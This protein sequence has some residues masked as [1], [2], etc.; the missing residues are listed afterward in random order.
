MAKSVLDK[1]VESR[2]MPVLFIG[3]GIS[4]RYLYNF[5]DW[6]NLLK[7]SFK[8]VN[9]DPFYYGQ[10]IE[11][12][13]R[14]NL[15]DFERNIRLAS[16]IENDYN[17]AFYSRKVKIKI[18]NSKNP[19]WVEQGISPYKM[20]LVN[21]F[22]KL[23]INR[24]PELQKEIQSFSML[25]N[26]ISAVITTNYDCFLEQEVFK[27]DYEVFCHQNE[28][29]SSDSYNVAEIYKIHG[30]VL[31]A[32]SI[33]ITERDYENFN[34]SR[35]LI[36]AKMLTLFAESPI[37]FMGYSFTDEN[38][39]CII[40]EFL[41]CLTPKELKNIS[42]H[43][44]F[45][46]YK[47]GERR[48]VEKKRTLFTVNKV[49]I[50]ITE[51]ETDNYNAVYDKLN[52]I[53]PGISASR[54]RA[55]RKIV[56]RIVDESVS[57]DAA[58]SIIVGIDDLDSV[59]ISN[60]PLAIA[61]GYRDNILNKI[62][63]GMVEVETIMEDILYNNKHLDPERMCLDRFKSISSTLLI[64]VFKY[65]KDCPVEIPKESKLYKYIAAH[66]TIN[67]IISKSQLKA[68]GSLPKLESKEN[69]HDVINAQIT[70][71]KKAG[72]LLKNIALLTADEIRHECKFLFEEASGTKI[73]STC[74]KRCV[75]YLDYIENYKEK[76]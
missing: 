66:E 8:E 40:E 62:G 19:K 27:N 71:D 3:S 11:R 37:I 24:D 25:K 72:V 75:M 61:I 76:S 48:L 6:E 31:D 21:F 49:S 7:L 39:Q 1:I 45:V 12:F 65:V 54:I 9:P 60:K 51:I 68:I 58:E 73:S 55:T 52:K 13:K 33:V 44:V 34:N 4:R 35:K 69:I 28:L 30:S 43:F 64:P 2:K 42:N 29:F 38:I 63:Y 32:K 57:S 53:L 67:K 59:D 20:F 47:K 16:I 14:E 18:G 15:S 74:F 5:P 56:K 46:S 70:F 23:N 41:S 22:R 17:A 50:P 26:K 10:Y 36:I